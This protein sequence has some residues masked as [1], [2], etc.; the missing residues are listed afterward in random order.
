MAI[1][2]S[3]QAGGALDIGQHL[4]LR[5]LL[6][7][8]ALAGCRRVQEQPCFRTRSCGSG[9]SC[10]FNH[11]CASGVCAGETC[12]AASCADGVQN[13]GEAGIDCGGPCGAN[14]PLG[15]KC[16][17]GLDCSFGSCAAGA[18]VAPQGGLPPTGPVAATIPATGGSV[19][20][21]SDQHVGVT[22]AFP[23]GA[24]ARPVAIQITPAGPERGEWARVKLEP[25]NAVFAKPVTVTFTLPA[26]VP[27]DRADVYFGAPEL[28][29][30]ISSTRSGL[31][32]TTQISSFGY[33][34]LLGSPL[35]AGAFGVAHDG[36]R[37]S[38]LF[39][40]ETKFVPGSFLAASPILSID[41]KIAI[42]Q[43]LYDAVLN[44]GDY[45]YAAGLAGFLAALH[46]KL[47][48]PTDGKKVRQFIANMGSASCK[49]LIQ[50][51]NVLLNS[52]A[53]CAPEL[54]RYTKPV[55]EF[56]RELMGLDQPVGNCPPFDDFSW[57]RL[58]ASKQAE[59]A[60]NAITDRLTWAK[61][62]CREW[63]AAKLSDLKRASCALI[64]VVLPV[65]PNTSQGS[66]GP[67][68][69]DVL[70][71]EPLYADEMAIETRLLGIP[72]LADELE[73]G[74]E[75]PMLAAVRKTEFGLCKQGGETSPVGA[76]LLRLPGDASVQ[77][78]AQYCAA[79]LGYTAL[80][81]SGNT[82]VTG[83]LAIDAPDG[84]TD[85]ATGAD[86]AVQGDGKLRLSGQ[87]PPLK[88]PE[89]LD[90]TQAARME[91]D[92]LVVKVAGQ[93][94]VRQSAGVTGDLL[95][96]QVSL[97][98]ADL[99]HAAGQDP[100]VN[101]NLD[102][103]VGRESPGCGGLYGAGLVKLFTLHLLANVPTKLALAGRNLGF[104]A[105]ALVPAGVSVVP[106]EH[107]FVQATLTHGDVP[108]KGSVVLV[109]KLN[110]ALSPPA[111]AWFATLTTDAA[112]NASFIADR[113]ST[114]DYYR[115]FYSENG[116]DC[117]IGPA[118]A[119]CHLSAIFVSA[120]SGI[121]VSNSGGAAPKN[122]TEQFTAKAQAG[123]DNRV[124][125][126]VTG[127]GSIDA[128]GLFTAFNIA[129]DWSV[130][131]T[132]VPY[133]AWSGTARAHVIFT[134]LDYVGTWSGT[135]TYD[136]TTVVLTDGGTI[137]GLPLADCTGSAATLTVLDCG[138]AAGGCG[139]VSGI[140][141]LKFDYTPCNNFEH[142]GQSNDTSAVSDDV[143]YY[144]D[145]LDLFVDGID[146]GTITIK[147]SFKITGG[148]FSQYSLSRYFTMSKAWP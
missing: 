128:N 22:L 110:S 144:G 109:Q 1:P 23:A 96:P 70:P 73:R 62:D 47:D 55:A 82:V 56:G 132:S 45:A 75:K 74:L 98:V 85:A 60:Q 142:V 99:F 79:A 44:N 122:G 5:L 87:L 125:W 37:S 112:G 108:L 136:P 13:G 15:T 117:P 3:H 38:A 105:D 140:D 17:S 90:G 46:Q 59:V 76:I 138:L 66:Q 118:T 107:A 68:L 106:G 35:P 39:A 24:V 126:T 42:A 50:K 65:A 97:A 114:S 51:M 6:I 111:Y 103:E 28:P 8:L 92:S 7:G 71:D 67:D 124:T 113:P 129:G 53:A 58:C 135:Q 91:M 127:G 141:Q 139:T 33:P 78:D 40:E 121:E 83:V 133:P 100:A 25:D 94:L 34:Q 20:A 32:V 12:Q 81:A 102:V 77:Q 21:V 48:D 137:W 69:G 41:Q 54:E 148:A 19:S 146:G 30:P 119:N 52:K 64:G 101:P 95:Q 84:A 36:L 131:A 27:G 80:D 16:T 145:K 61:C 14:C 116:A 63:P 134:N 31:T 123:S 147:G 2:Q 72:A 86:V 10:I 26:G 57:L 143:P 11:Q 29:L 18:C 93:E 130:K 120:S 104:P 49:A 88:C 43:Q 89:S 4:S 115:A 9:V